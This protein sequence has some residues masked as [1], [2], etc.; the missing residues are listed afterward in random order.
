[1]NA[2]LGTVLTEPDLPQLKRKWAIYSPDELSQR[3]LELGGRTF[4]VEGLVPERSIALVVG[5]SG[6]GKSPLLYQ[7]ALCVAS[8]I[9]F[10]GR[11][12]RQ[13]RVL[14]LDYENGVGDVED[15]V[16]QLSL[17]LGLT[18]KPEDLLLWNLNDSP[19]KWGQPGYRAI[20]MI[21]EVRPS[22]AIVDSI[23]AF[24]PGIEE[25]NSTATQV[26]Q[27]FR[28][29]MR[30]C[31]TS[32]AAIH[33]L[34]KQSDKPE[35]APPPLE[36]SNFR[37]WFRQAR[38]CRYLINGSDVRIG[39]DEPGVSGAVYNSGSTQEEI[40]LVLRGFGR[41]RG[42]IPLTYLARVLD[43][44]G[45]ALGYKKLTGASL[46]FNEGQ[47]ATFGKLPDAFRFKDAKH[48]YGKGPQAT[49][50]F[51]KKCCNLGIL[52]KVG[53]GRYEKVPKGE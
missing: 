31:G 12:V 47:S 53:K 15:M 17:H 24:H 2:A 35:Y 5:D 49:D 37:Q 32:I 25:K 13:G 28:S 21:R 36:G 41:V 46:L 26:F 30:D 19:P 10:L 4:V 40:A 52:H 50:D 11:P 44:G 14:Y 23:T 33:H 7:A 51:L 3:T 39:I 34:K 6:L 8:G 20:D 9:P 43:E 27:E 48:A 18:G 16:T 22:L 1:M 29:I 45:E 42:E 38:G